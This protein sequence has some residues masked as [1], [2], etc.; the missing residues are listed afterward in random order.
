MTGQP[1]QDPA[2]D[3]D[4]YDEL[5][6]QAVQV[7][8]AAARLT[9]TSTGIGIGIGIGIGKGIGIPLHH[10]PATVYTHPHHLCSHRS[11]QPPTTPRHER[12]HCG[13]HRLA[14]SSSLLF[15]TPKPLP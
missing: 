6:A 8:T 7:L 10:D 3:G 4:R 14:C 12:P 5:F 13:V 2:P 1:T 11:C 9:G 15:P